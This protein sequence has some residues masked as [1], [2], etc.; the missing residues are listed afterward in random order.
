M[1]KYFG[2]FIRQAA[3]KAATAAGIA[4]STESAA[5]AIGYHAFKTEQVAKAAGAE[6]APD[7]GSA[8]AG[9]EGDWATPFWW[10]QWKGAQPKLSLQ[11]RVD[12]CMKVVIGGEI[13]KDVNEL[14]VCT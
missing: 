11:E 7:A 1:Y 6:A 3:A 8:D 13:N 9:S 12:N 2:G 4:T 10:T 5:F 14:K